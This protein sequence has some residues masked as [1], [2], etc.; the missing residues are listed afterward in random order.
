MVEA[1]REVGREWKIAEIRKQIAAGTY[2]TPD[3]VDA[4]VEEMLRRFEEPSADASPQ[5]PR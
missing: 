1:N 5:K 2:E 4:A 3:K